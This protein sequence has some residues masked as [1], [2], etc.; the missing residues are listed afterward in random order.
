[1]STPILPKIINDPVHG[2]ITIPKGLLMDV[3]DSPEFQRLRRIKQMG[4]GSVVY[5]GAHHTRFS[6]ALGAFHLM[7]Q[8]LD[9]LRSKGVDIS[10]AEYEATQAAILLHDVGHGPFSHALEKVIIRGLNHEHMSLALMHRLNERFG[11][12]LSLTIEIFEGKY[13][14][15]FLHQ[16]VSSQLDMDRLDYL[17]RDSFFTGVVE[18]MVG[19]DRILKVLNVYQDKLV[20]E[21]KGIYSIENFIVARRIM[22]WQ[23]YLH[24]AAMAAEQMLV[25]ILKRA[26]ELAEN[27]VNIWLSDN[28]R[29][30]FHHDIDPGSLDE[31]TLRRYLSLDDSDVEYA[32]KQWTCAP[33]RVLS[34]LCQRLVTR[35]LLKTRIQSAPFP[36]HELR[37][38]QNRFAALSGFSAEET[39]Y[40]VFDGQVFNQA[41]YPHTDE[42]IIIY[43]RDGKLQDLPSAADLTNIHALATPVVKHYLCFPAELRD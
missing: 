16:L 39:A 42:P 20:C 33:D 40:F 32:L 28:L 23:V 27:Q 41:Y 25:H 12:R 31:E 18:G 43:F 14:R 38:M 29:F 8:A 21:S 17:V 34:G 22:Y 36:E 7:T 6:H 24:K 4:M 2:F 3:I 11:G 26:R 13:P 9:V 19:A 37:D 1:M 10:D 15:T 30:F 5:P 35:D